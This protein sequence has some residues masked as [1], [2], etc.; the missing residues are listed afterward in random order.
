M[1]PWV[2]ILHTSS[3]FDSAS[4]NLLLC[5]TTMKCGKVHISKGYVLCKENATLKY[6]VENKFATVILSSPSK[7]AYCIESSTV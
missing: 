7:T 4:S 3:S 5:G 2:P 1:V 6:N